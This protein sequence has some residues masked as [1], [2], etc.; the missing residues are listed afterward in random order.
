M[1]PYLIVRVRIALSCTEGLRPFFMG[2]SCLLGEK[3]PNC[4]ELY[5]G[6]ATS[7]RRGGYYHSADERI[8]IALS[9]TEGLRPLWTAEV[10]TATLA[11]SELP[12]AVRRD[13]SP[14]APRRHFF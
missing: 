11:A 4:P 5:G 13:C 1:L 9:C 10:V 3:G 8:R 14:D 6:I 12:S 7:R 2:S